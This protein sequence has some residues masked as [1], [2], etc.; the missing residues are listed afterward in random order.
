VTALAELR[1]AVRRF[2]DELGRQPECDS[3]MRGWD[4]EF[5]RAL[6]DRGWIGMTVP[7]QY[8][9]GGRSFVERFVV[10]EELLRAG[11]P[12][13]AH[14]VAD[15]QIA[16]TIVRHANER[17]RQELL[18][19]ICRGE[20]YFCVGM[21]EPN[22]GS[23]V[24]AIATRAEHDGSEWVINGQKTWTTGAGEAHYGYVIA[25]TSRAER[26]H[27][28]LSEFV[29]PMDAEGVSVRPIED[30]AGERH[31]NEVFFDDVRV[32][33]WRLV[34]EPGTAFKQVIRQLD[35]ERSGPERVLS[36]YPLLDSLLAATDRTAELDAELGALAAQVAALRAMSF[37]IAREMDDGE[38]P[39]AYA[40]LVK[41]LGNQLEQRVARVAVEVLDVQPHL[42]E[43]GATTVLDR[44]V[45]RAAVAAPAFTLRGGSVEILREVVARRMLELGG[46][47]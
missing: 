45:W 36:T 43:A 3:W 47:R 29:V 28:G 35:Y 30:L 11:A 32:E 38:P 23:D 26:R 40:A 37:R 4:P 22:A 42:P 20:T 27:E 10:T 44:H 18:P 2:I 25:R 24:A 16:P 31:F 8:G 15:R 13:A 34:G 19:G 6:G 1:S 39:S 5:S 46:W 7:E 21:S 33:D 14:W 9:G 41:D 17:L 12:V